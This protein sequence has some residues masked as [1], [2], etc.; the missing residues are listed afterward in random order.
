MGFNCPAAF[1]TCLER[2]AGRAALELYDIVSAEDPNLS[3]V[4][5]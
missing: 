5:N 2:S 4:L 3:L 1:W